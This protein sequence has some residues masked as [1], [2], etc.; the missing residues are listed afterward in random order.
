ML[1]GLLDVEDIS[2]NAG[3]KRTVGF[4]VDYDHSV[5]IRP[6]LESKEDTLCITTVG[7]VDIVCLAVFVGILDIGSQRLISQNLMFVF[8]TYLTI[9]TSKTLQP[10]AS[11]HWDS[12]GGFA[13]CKPERHFPDLDGKTSSGLQS[14]YL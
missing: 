5:R 3:G 10:S 6:Q 7:A 4:D 1:T 14:T 8:G 12:I 9:P 2:E 13:S 11:N